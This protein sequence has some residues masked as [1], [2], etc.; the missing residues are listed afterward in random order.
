MPLIIERNPSRSSFLLPLA[1]IFTILT[2][3]AVLTGWFLNI[4]VLKSG[5]PGLVTMKFNTALCF[6]LAGVSFLLLLKY[7]TLFP[8]S[9]GKV[10]LE[11]MGILAAIT[12]SQGLFDWNSSLDQFF[13]TDYYSIAT[14]VPHPG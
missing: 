9:L 13:V 8:R 4:Q 14:H 3:I 7:D 1:G 6:I 2:G 11:A 12:F 5:L 10:L